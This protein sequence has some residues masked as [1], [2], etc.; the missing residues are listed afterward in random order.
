MRTAEKSVGE[1]KEGRT[2]GNSLLQKNR[3]RR[4]VEGVYNCIS[5]GGLSSE[6]KVQFEPPSGI[7]YISTRVKIILAT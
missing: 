6:I 3:K 2:W 5:A 4:K 7:L 1:S